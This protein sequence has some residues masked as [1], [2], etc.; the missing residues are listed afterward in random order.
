MEI[1]TYDTQRRGGKGKFA[2]DVHEEDVVE[3]ILVARTHDLILLF[4][5]RG[6]TY[7]IRGFVIPM[8]RSRT[9]KGSALAQL[10]Q[11]SSGE[12]VRSMI[13]IHEFND[14]EFL[15]MA[16]K[17]G[18]IKK[19][20]IREYS[21][22]RRNGKAAI[23]LLEGDE[24]IDVRKTDGS[25]HIVLATANGMAI[26]FREI[27]VRNTGRR[28]QGVIG[29]SLTNGDSVIGMAVVSQEEAQS[30]KPTHS[31]LTVTESGYG[32]RTEFSKYRLIRRGGKGVLNMNVEKSG[33]V[34]GIRSAS[35]ND[36][37]MV[38][39]I[40]GK[41]VRSKISEIRQTVS[42]NVKG[43]R[44]CRVG[45]DDRVVAFASIQADELEQNEASTSESPNDAEETAPG[46][47]QSVFD[48]N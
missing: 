45:S 13:A 31:L 26:R 21:K 8:A 9:S 24:L 18:K 5:N 48:K 25:K 11:L 20:S 7:G 17:R 28:T 23:A 32:K 40:K 47:N 34:V 6:K 3:E 15:I 42:R 35:Q 43:V 1:G 38:I 27:D 10:I 4:T 29:I 33:P 39:T 22:I 46:G 30:E 12:Y 36:E 2:L 44:V 41:L 37:L 19:T 16:T 14:N